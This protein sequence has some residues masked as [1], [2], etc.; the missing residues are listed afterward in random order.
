MFQRT[1]LVVHNYIF[2]SQII[3]GFYIIRIKPEGLFVGVNSFFVQVK[4]TV[5]NCQV[6]MSL[7][8]IRV[9]TNRLLVSRN[10]FC[11]EP[12]TICL[13]YTYY[14]ADDTTLVYI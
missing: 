4:F 11:V 9:D 5:A 6:K 8:K 1:F 7:K 14:A 3:V 12:K 13:L 2:N 10:G